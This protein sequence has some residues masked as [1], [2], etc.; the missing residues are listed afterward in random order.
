MLRCDAGLPAHRAGR[1]PRGLWPEISRAVLAKH[2][3]V[4]ITTVTGML[5][6]RTQI[7]VRMIQ[8]I[9]AQLHIPMGT[10]QGQWQEQKQQ[11]LEQQRDKR[12]KRAKREH[13]KSKKKR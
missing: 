9:A 8:M 7:P 5:L 12:D 2:F 11:Y 10:L 1:P 13:M 6:G 3:G 4:H